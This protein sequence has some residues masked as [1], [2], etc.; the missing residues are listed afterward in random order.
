MC[1]EFF[2]PFQSTQYVRVD[3]T[4]THIIL[5]KI[6]LQIVLKMKGL[7]AIDL[8]DPDPIPTLNRESLEVR[9]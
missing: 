9:F 3:I 8:R 4:H 5:F 7:R 1:K 6:Q 2:F